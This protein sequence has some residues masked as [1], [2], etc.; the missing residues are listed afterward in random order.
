MVDWNYA[1]DIHVQ[2]LQHYPIITGI[3]DRIKYQI[4][5]IKY[6]ANGIENF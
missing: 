6:E 2:K 4:I 3:A 5:L 1:S